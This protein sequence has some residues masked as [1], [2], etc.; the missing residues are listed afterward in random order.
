MPSTTGNIEGIANVDSEFSE[1]SAEEVLYTS[2]IEPI[3]EQIDVI[4]NSFHQRF[5][6]STKNLMI[7]WNQLATSVENKQLNETCDQLLQLAE[8][9]P[10]V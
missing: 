2:M 3:S 4:L 10:T 7:I 1:N 9:Y 8:A 5:K 6:K